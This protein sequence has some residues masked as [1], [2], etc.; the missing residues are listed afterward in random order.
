MRCQDICTVPVIHCY[1]DTTAQ[2][3]ARIMRD[4]RVGFVPVLDGKERVAGVVTDRDLVVNVLARG[5][6]SNVSVESVMSRDVVT[7]K[8][9]DDVLVAEDT[10]VRAQR[11]RILVVDGQGRCVGVLSLTDISQRESPI[12]AGRI[13]NSVAKRK[14]RADDDASDP[15]P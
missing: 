15:K 10:I 11:S 12:R 9:D 4:M 13:L 5:R 1:L 14:F 7:C 3:C 8:P 2:E 6:D